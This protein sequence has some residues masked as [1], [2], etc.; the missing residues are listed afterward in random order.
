MTDDKITFIEDAQSKKREQ[1][2][3]ASG[4]CRQWTPLDAL[5]QAISEIE[6]GDL[7]PEAIYI[8]FYE[9]DPDNRIVSYPFYCAGGTNIQITGLLAHHLAICTNS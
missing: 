8:A 6:A 1:S 2:A 4:D 5:K 3:E 7:N 9:R